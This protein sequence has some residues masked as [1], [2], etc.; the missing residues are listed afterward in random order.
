MRPERNS[1]ARRAISR[2]SLLFLRRKRARKDIT[3]TRAGAGGEIGLE[4]SNGHDQPIADDK[5][6]IGIE[7]LIFTRKA[8]V[9][10]R[11][12]DAVISGG[13]GS[14]IDGRIAR[15]ATTQSRRLR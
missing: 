12:S 6:V 15:R 9:I 4:I 11:E 2:S 14:G 8:P 3:L 5:V 1:N 7:N 13:A 10:I